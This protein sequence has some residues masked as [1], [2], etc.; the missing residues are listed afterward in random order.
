MIVF[1]L[2]CSRGHLFEGW[3]RNSDSFEE[4]NA[5]KLVS[6]PFCNDTNIRRVLSPVT[7]KASSR[8]EP[9]KEVTT[10][11]YRRLAKEIV[12]YVNKNFD[13]VGHHF[14]KEALKMHYGVS[15]KRNIR[16]SATAEEE[17]LLREEK[18]EF[19]KIPVPRT[20]EHKKN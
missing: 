15:E 11:D 2:Q 7:T 1:D 9:E 12:D 6:C 3:F 20:D 8:E 17:K 19:F 18:I 5:N 13:D 14:T 16:G 10:I 4:Q